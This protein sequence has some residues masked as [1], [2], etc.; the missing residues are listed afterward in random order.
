METNLLWHKLLNLV[1]SSDELTYGPPLSAKLHISDQSIVDD[2]T[3]CIQHN[4]DIRLILDND[5]DSLSIGQ[6]V[7]L[8]IS[9]R[10]GFGLIVPNLDALLKAQF[11]MVREPVRYLL[12]DEKISNTDNIDSNHRI[13]KYRAT[14]EFINTLK[15]AA[16][17]LDK[18]LPSLVFIS[19]GKFE[20]PISYSV[21]NLID[22]DLDVLKDFNSIAAENIHKTQC[23]SILSD[24]IVRTARP[25]N[26][27]NRF[28]FLLS[29]VAELKKQF[30]EG[31]KLYA[32]GFSYQK[33]K[34]EIEAARIEY[35]GKI[36]KVFSDIQNQLLGIPVATIIVATQ[37]KQHSVVDMNFWGSLAVLIGSFVFMLLMHFLIKN[38]KHTLDVLGDEISRQKLK[39]EYE[40][41]AIAPNLINTFIS[42]QDRYNTQK[43]ILNV[44]DVIVFVG[45]TMALFFFYQLSLPTQKL[46]NE[47]FMKVS[48]LI[49]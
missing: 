44:V 35:S 22:L 43:R 39:L 40:H 18:D 4:N 49:L 30:D 3:I 19:D 41:A 28:S 13:N 32:T 29:H 38:Q 10:F 12:L 5:V 31:Y 47:I 33:I 2:L 17:F 7:E 27:N 34:D 37:M 11:S 36:H 6:K 21:S 42:L 45:F 20:I 8:T 1:R 23:A 48:N 25:I 16:A 26:V 24:A 46:T 15:W 9:P 14:L